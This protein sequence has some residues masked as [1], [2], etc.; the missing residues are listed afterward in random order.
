MEGRSARRIQSGWRPSW[1]LPILF[2][3]SPRRR[4]RRAGHENR[5]PAPVA[6]QHAAI[7]KTLVQF[8][9]SALPRCVFLVG[10][11]AARANDVGESRI[12]LVNSNPAPSPA[13]RREFHC[14]AHAANMSLYFR[15]YRPSGEADFVH[16]AAI[17][18]TF[19]D[20]AVLPV[21]VS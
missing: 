15:F 17:I 21:R 6:G 10:L 3:A 19:H 1:I 4:S 9:A 2:A 16:E 7:H 20:D 8:V 11:R 12:S 5:G 18:Q 14:R 13:R